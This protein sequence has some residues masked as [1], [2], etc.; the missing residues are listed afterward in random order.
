MAILALYDITG[1]QDYIFSSSKMKENLGASII[2][3]KIFDDYLIDAIQE[4]DNINTRPLWKEYNNFLIKTDSKIKAEVIY[5]GGGNALVV[6]KDKESFKSVNKILSNKVLEK[7]AG[8]LSIAVSCI[9]TNFN[10]F[11]QDMAENLIPEIKKKKYEFNQ[12][13]PLLGISITREGITDGLPAQEKINDEYVS[14]SAHL[15]RVEADSPY[16]DFLLKEHT[17]YKFPKDFDA[18][19][20]SKGENHIAV[21]HIDGNN[22]GKTI[23]KLLKNEENYEKAVYKIRTFSKNIKITYENVMKKLVQYITTALKDEKLYKKLEVNTSENKIFLPIRPVVLN[24]DDVT[25]VCNG[26]I[27]VSCAEK[28]LKEIHNSAVEVGKEK[29][30]LSACAGVAIVKSHFPFY[31]TYELSE[32]LCKS[33]K[34]KAKTLALIDDKENVGSWMDYHIVFSGLTLGLDEIRK[35]Y[36]QVPGMKEPNKLTHTQPGGITS[37]SQQYNLLWRPWC[38]IGDT[39]EKYMWDK[40]KLMYQY[41][42]RDDKKWPRSKLKALRNEAIKSDVSIKLLLKELKSRGKELPAF[43]GNKDNFFIDNQAPYFDVL[44]LLDFYTE[45][46]EEEEAK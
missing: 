19:G 45:F 30:Q 11:Y 39:E 33:A 13:Y 3:Q 9:D 43:N 17:K 23:E 21:V 16:F 35:N 10:N 32:Q 6:Y 2:V 25:F 36:Y 44:E 29:I 5:I 4:Y 26:R 40:F 28:F 12:T 27:G 38:I 20:Q 1:I 42:T 22:M 37:E 18:L 7:A 41:F 24:G 31:R 34:K 15:K 8:I 14:L 46:P